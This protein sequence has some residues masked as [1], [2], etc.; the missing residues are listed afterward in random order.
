MLLQHR[1]HATMNERVVHH[2]EQSAKSTCPQAI[3]TP[4]PSVF[5]CSYKFC[6]YSSVSVSRSASFGA[7]STTSRKSPSG[8]FDR[9]CAS[10]PI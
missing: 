6:L 4:E 9:E 7:Q 8:I 2:R 1:K 10:H 5:V 3:R